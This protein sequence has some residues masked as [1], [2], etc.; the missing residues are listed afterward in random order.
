MDNDY[1]GDEGHLEK[2]D[3]D[4]VCIQCGTVNSEGTLLCKVC[5]NNLRDQRNQRMTS[6]QA[7]EMDQ[8]GPKA[9]VWASGIL[10]VL[11]VGLVLSTLYNQTYIVN[12]LMGIQSQSEGVSRD[13]WRGETGSKIDALVLELETNFPTEDIALEARS[14]EPSSDALDG[15]YVLFVDDLYVGAAKAFTE[16]DYLY[17]GAILQSGEEVRGRARDEGDFYLMVPEFGALKTRR[18]VFSVQGVAS[19]QGS[20]IIECVGDDS[21]SRYSCLAYKVEP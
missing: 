1:L 13:M 21:R 9:R 6:D 15:V 7:L 19:P 3:A 14:I 11:A 5:G 17:F 8:S 18:H 10:F 20:G 4:A 16:D 2:L 12:W